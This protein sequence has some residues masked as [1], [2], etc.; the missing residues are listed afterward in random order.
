MMIKTTS[1]MMILLL[2]MRMLMIKLLLMITIIKNSKLSGPWQFRIKDFK[3]LLP[4]LHIGQ[5]DDGNNSVDKEDILSE[6]DL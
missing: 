4:R 5:C 1:R 3:V 2:L 6:N